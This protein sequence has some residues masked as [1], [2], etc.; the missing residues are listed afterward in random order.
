MT[1]PTR[2]AGALTGLFAAAYVAAGEIAGL[3]HW[4]HQLIGAAI[5]AAAALLVRPAESGVITGDRPP[6]AGAAPESARTPE[7]AQQEPV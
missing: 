7:G 1:T 5:V 4:A 3:P 6:A 2:L